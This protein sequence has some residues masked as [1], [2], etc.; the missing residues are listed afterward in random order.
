[1]GAVDC[2]RGVVNGIEGF[3]LLQHGVELLA[4]NVDAQCD[5]VGVTKWE[6]PRAP[7]K[8]LLLSVS[9]VAR[10]GSDIAGPKLSVYTDNEEFISVDCQ[11]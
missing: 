4:C 6:T 1:M 8:F 5:D 3:E 11:C 10:L 9:A 2:T 7:S